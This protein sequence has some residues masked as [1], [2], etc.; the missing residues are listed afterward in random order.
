MQQRG[1]RCNI[2]TLSWGEVL[3]EEQKEPEWLINP[4]LV[5]EGI[6]LLWGK[7][8]TGKSP[9][10][11]SLALAV[12]SGISWFGLPTKQ[13]R[14][15][16][17]DVD[18]PESVAISR[19]QNIRPPK[20][21][22]ENVFFC[23]S[24][25]LMMGV[26]GMQ[27]DQH[28]EL[29]ELNGKLKPDLVVLN[30]LRKLHDLDDK[31][32]KTPKLVYATYQ[33]LFPQAALLFV[34]HERKSSTDPRAQYHGDEAFSGSQHWIDDAQVGLH[35]EKFKSERENLRL[36]HRK[37]QVSETLNPL[38]LKLLDDGSNLECPLFEDLLCT[39]EKL[40][41]GLTGVHCDD[42]VAEVRGISR[43]TARGRR[44]QIEAGHFPG[45]RN[46][47]SPD[48]EIRG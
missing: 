11:W 48:K 26:G 22:L 46:F 3:E 9:L 31:D 43:S 1:G 30:T 28:A 29:Q 47:L 21:A 37:S 32:S 12:G 45:S 17:I 38:G 4:F 13:G 24:K 42:A 5:K 36:W 18:S 25:P 15:L 34:H 44:M 33:Y 6:T 41:E 23:I 8:S 39:Y 7:Y 2:R 40:N 20:E 10:T 19:L 14:V 16:Y 27:E 35:I